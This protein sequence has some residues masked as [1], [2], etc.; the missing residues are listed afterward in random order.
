MV[1]AGTSN[2]SPNGSNSYFCRLY[3]ILDEFCAKQHGI[4]YSDIDSFDTDHKKVT[5]DQ[6]ARKMVVQSDSRIFVHLD[7]QLVYFL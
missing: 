4:F 6:G 2:G 5:Q 3:I 1:H 7:Y